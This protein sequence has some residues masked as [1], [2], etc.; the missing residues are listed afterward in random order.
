[1]LF[2]SKKSQMVKLE[3]RLDP[4]SNMGANPLIFMVLLSIRKQKFPK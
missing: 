4:L 2:I 1:M 3:K